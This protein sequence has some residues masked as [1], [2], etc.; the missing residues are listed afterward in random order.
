MQATAI[1]SVYITWWITFLIPH[2]ALR[3][4]LP[5]QQWISISWNLQRNILASPCPKALLQF[6][7]IGGSQT[8]TLV[9]IHVLLTRRHS[10]RAHTHTHVGVWRTQCLFRIIV[11]S[12]NMIRDAPREILP[13]HARHIVAPTTAALRLRMWLPTYRKWH[14]FPLWRTI[15]KVSRTNNLVDSHFSPLSLSPFLHLIPPP[16][17]RQLLNQLNAHTG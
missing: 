7:F 17:P 10:I 3:A 9:S 14:L 4:G 12:I 5:T 16:S 2:P 13:A 15:L 8:K 6:S 1:W 11:Y